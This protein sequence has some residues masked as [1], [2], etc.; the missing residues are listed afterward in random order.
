[1]LAEHSRQQASDALNIIVDYMNRFL[2]DTRKRKMSF[3]LRHALAMRT[4]DDLHDI[5]RDSKY[6]GASL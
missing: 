6:R 2:A 5:F 1:V 4:Y 3:G